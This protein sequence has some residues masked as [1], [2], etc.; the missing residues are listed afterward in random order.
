MKI[1]SH[2]TKNVIYLP[3]II[4]CLQNKNTLY[5]DIYLFKRYWYIQFDL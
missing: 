4:I 5:I 2:K 1:E 3:N